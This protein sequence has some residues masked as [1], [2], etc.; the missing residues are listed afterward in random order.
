MQANLAEYESSARFYVRAL[1]MN[2][3]AFGVWGY[4][5][6]VLVC[7]GRTDLMEAVEDENLVAL[8]NALPL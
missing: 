5:R 8:Q 7:A 2:P 1:G 3:Q 4:L 6:N